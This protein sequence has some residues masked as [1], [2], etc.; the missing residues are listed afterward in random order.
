[1]IQRCAKPSKTQNLLQGSSQC[2]VP[3]SIYLLTNKLLLA[4]ET[5]VAFALKVG[6]CGFDHWPDHT[7][8]IKMVP[9]ASLVGTQYSGLDLGN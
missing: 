1:M 2:N 8:T 4:V 7:K 6:G 3:V 9:I 5:V